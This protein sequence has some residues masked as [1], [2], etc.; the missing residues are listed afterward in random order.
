MKIDDGIDKEELKEVSGP[1]K[2]YARFGALGFQMAAV[3][4]LAVWGGR[5]LDKTIG[6]KFPLFTLV[7]MLGALAGVVWS[8][9]RETRRKRD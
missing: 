9:V 7:L 4:A 6:W 5:W 1:A 2:S 3:I 8:V